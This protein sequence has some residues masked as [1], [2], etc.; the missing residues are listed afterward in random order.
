MSYN[1]LLSHN[2]KYESLKWAERG[3]PTYSYQT[4]VC[5]NY[6]QTEK[7]HTIF[8]ALVYSKSVGVANGLLFVWLF[9]QRKL[10]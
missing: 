4:C 8:K 3:F 5:R 9:R 2:P 7:L 1:I 6:H 10:Q